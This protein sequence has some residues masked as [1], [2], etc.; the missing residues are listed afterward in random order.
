M[1]KKM[2]IAI[3]IVLTI[4]TIN[5]S[6]AQDVDN[7]TATLSTDIDNQTIL[8]DSSLTKTEIDVVS[9]TTFDVIGSNFKIR[10]VD[11]NKTSIANSKVT[12]TINGNVFNRTTNDNGV[13]SL[14]LRLSD[15]SYNITT[16][17]LGDSIYKDSSKTTLVTINNTRIVDEGL[18]NSQIQNIIDNAKANNIILFKGDSYDDVNLILNKSLTL[19]S[20]SNTRLKSS[21]SEPVITIRGKAAS[22]STVKGFNIQGNGMGI[23]AIYCDYVNILANEITSGEEGIVSVNT[24]Y[25]NISQ[26][27]IV[28]NGKSGILVLNDNY[29]YITYNN[30]ASNGDCGIEVS[31]SNNTYIYSNLITGNKYYGISITNTTHGV[32]YGQGPENLHI[33]NNTISKNG[34]TGIDIARAADNL[35]ITGNTIDSNRYIGISINSVSSNLIQ[36]NVIS[37]HIHI[38]IKFTDDYEKPE[39]QEISYNAFILNTKDLEARETNYDEFVN[40]LEL[41]DNWHTDYGFVCPKIKTNRISLVVSHLGG[42]YFQATFLDS[43]GNVA[44]LLPDRTLIYTTDDGRVISLTISGGT[45]VFKVTDV[46]EDT[47]ETVTDRSKRTADYD[48]NLPDDGIEEY[49]GKSPEYSSYPS[50]NKYDLYEDINGNGGDGAGDD[51]GFY[52]GNSDSSKKS[53]GVGN[54]TFSQKTEPSS[55]SNSAVNEVSQNYDSQSTTSSVSSSQSG[56]VGSSNSPSGGKQSVVKQIIIDEDDIFRVTGISFIILLII[57]TIGF[58]YKDDIKEMKSKR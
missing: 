33:V 16:K 40:Q 37:N 43:N 11:E 13:A 53:G 44:S 50:I 36:S 4:F 10:L 51:E 9:N 2:F 58:Y 1:N 18:S 25:L 45:S 57:L 22:L 30:I 28:K 46:S 7:S 56:D 39:N 21:S 31:K 24:T 17:F 49:N 6:V 5:F 42:D 8:K 32:D 41:N 19:V 3:L 54:S 34:G 29:T 23:L 52:G 12:F 47:L 26:N 27:N 15:G 20:T 38:A 48:K 35:R 14:K 55:K